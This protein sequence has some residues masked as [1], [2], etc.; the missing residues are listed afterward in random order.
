MAIRIITD[1]SSDLLPAAAA[2]MGIRIIPL[3]VQLGDITYWDGQTIDRDTFYTMLQTSQQLP[4]T[5]QPTPDA[6]LQQ[7][8]QAKDAGDQVVAVLLSGALSG[9]VQSALI[10]KELCQYDDIHIV[11]SRSATAGI[12]LLLH[13]ACLM[14]DSGSSAPE[15]AAS[16][17]ELKHRVRIFAVVDTLEYLRR[18]G[19]LSDLAANIGT[20]TKLKPTITV[21]DGA[22]AIVGKSFGSAAATKHLLKLLQ[23]HPADSRYPLHLVF[24]D[25][26]ANGA[27]LAA[28]MAELGILPSHPL[29]S[30]VGPAIGTHVGPGAFGAAYIEA[31]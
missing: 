15:I 22:V 6:F 3:S 18:G 27:P 25:D 20:V 21:R 4:T 13:Q 19:R 24:T 29:Y 14:R 9:T 1:S 12:Q 7:F 26:A 2:A 8:Q 5:S 31:L 23:E 11:D 30:G 16:L 10:A 28:K 17:E